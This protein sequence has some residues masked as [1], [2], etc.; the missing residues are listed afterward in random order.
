MLAKIVLGRAGGGVL[1][2]M[3]VS[4]RNQ[5]IELSIPTHLSPFRVSMF[6]P[7]LT[8]VCHSHVCAAW[9]DSPN[10]L[11]WLPPSPTPRPHALGLLPGDLPWDLFRGRAQSSP[12]KCLLRNGRHFRTPLGSC[13]NN[14]PFTSSHATAPSGPTHHAGSRHIVAVLLFSPR[15]LGNVAV[16]PMRPA[17]FSLTRKK[18]GGLF[19]SR[20]SRLVR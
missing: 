14:Q 12:S 15:G 13:L 1:S 8:A 7:G 5:T 2:A 18:G 9:T 6:C 19:G 11:D 3:C 20:R 4:F 17:P 10:P 16:V